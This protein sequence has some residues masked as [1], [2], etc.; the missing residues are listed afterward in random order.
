MH[1]STGTGFTRQR[2]AN[3]QGAW[4]STNTTAGNSQ[5]FTGDF[6]GD[7]KTDLAKAWNVNN[8]IYAD[9]HLATGAGFSMHR[10]ANA[11]GNWIST[12]SSAG[13]S[14]WAVED[15][16]GDGRSDLAKTWNDGGTIS[17]DVHRSKGDAFVMWQPERGAGSWMPTNTIAGTGTWVTGDFDGAGNGDLALV[18]NANGTIYMDAHLSN[19]NQAVRDVLTRVTN[20]L[21]RPDLDH[22]SAGHAR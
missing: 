21:G 18:W 7:G 1:V 19:R 8:L 6:N 16:D 3:A 22:A 2:W 20:P 14:E 11:Q 9:V 17:L 10:W 5:W 15:F 12:N 4:I 13:N